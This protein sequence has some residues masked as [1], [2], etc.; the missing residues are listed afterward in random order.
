VHR[1]ISVGRVSLPRQSHA[2]VPAV[3]RASANTVV[4]ADGFACRDQIGQLTGRRA[5]HLAAVLDGHGLPDHSSGP[6]H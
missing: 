5:F 6:A 4:I 1:T 2:V 3:R